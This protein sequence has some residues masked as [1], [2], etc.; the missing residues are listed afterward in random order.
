[1]ERPHLVKEFLRKEDAYR[2]IKNKLKLEYD[3][4]AR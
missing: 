3:N 2:D 1:L 4:L